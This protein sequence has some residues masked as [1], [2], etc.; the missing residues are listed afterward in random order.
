MRRVA[1]VVISDRPVDLYLARCLES[2]D[3]FARYSFTQRIIL[4][5]TEHRL[6]ASGAVNEAWSQVD[7]DW[8]VHVEE[9]FILTEPLDI[10]GMAR[11]LVANPKLASLCLLRQPWS[12]PEIEAGGILGLYADRMIER[13]TLGYPWVQHDCFFS[14]N[15]SLVPRR[16]F[17]QGFPEGSEPAQT[18]RL[19]A[20]GFH[21]GYWGA[22]GDAP[23][24]E[25]IGH[26]R[27][28]GSVR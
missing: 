22:R 27:A 7:A 26:L 18:E 11:V 19:L 16:V 8:L 5:D 6:T 24:C 3:R 4:T 1:L 28:A 23:R 10:E 14:L 12:E 17:E 20:Q 15:P 25:H 2:L 9:D 13:Q 21:F